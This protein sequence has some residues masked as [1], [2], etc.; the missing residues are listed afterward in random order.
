[1]KEVHARDF[2]RKRVQRQDSYLGGNFNRAHGMMK[3][4]TASH[5]MTVGGD[6]GRCE[7]WNG[8]IKET[9][10][11]LSHTLS[12]VVGWIVSPQKRYIEILTSGKSECDLIIRVFEN[13]IK[14]KLD[15]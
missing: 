14:L 10:V 8:G 2:R 4:W 12:C 11:E 15:H 9:S 7:P 6:D 5:S 3:V 13:I 1:M